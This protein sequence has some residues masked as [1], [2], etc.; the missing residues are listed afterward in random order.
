M[1][2]IASSHRASRSVYIEY[3]TWGQ[4][5]GSLSTRLGGK[6]KAPRIHIAVYDMYIYNYQIYS[7]SVCVKEKRNT[8]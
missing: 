7:N 3:K 5:Q 2:C 8:N 6:G 1:D 4:G